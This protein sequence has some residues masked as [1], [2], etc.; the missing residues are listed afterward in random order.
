MEKKIIAALMCAFNV[1]YGT[2]YSERIPDIFERIGSIPILY[3]IF[4]PLHLICFTFLPRIAS[5]ILRPK[6]YS[7]QQ[8]IKVTFF[9]LFDHSYCFQNINNFV[10][11][12]GNQNKHMFI[13]IHMLFTYIC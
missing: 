13:H 4:N 7:A 2:G 1:Q 12:K 11:L 5:E 6:V 8:K 3:R 9:F 10:R